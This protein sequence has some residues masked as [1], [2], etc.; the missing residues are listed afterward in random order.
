[1]AWGAGWRKGEGVARRGKQWAAAPWVWRCSSCGCGKNQWA[2]QCCGNCGKN[3]KDGWGGRRAQGRE[4]SAWDAGPPNHSRPHKQAAAPTA[5]PSQGAPEEKPTGEEA[6]ALAACLEVLRTLGTP[7]AKTALQALEA[8]LGPAA[9]TSKDPEKA[10]GPLLRKR[11]KK[12]AQL[13]RQQE[14]V[15]ACEKRLAEAKAREDEISEKLRAIQEE[16]SE[17]R[18]LLADEPPEQDQQTPPRPAR[19][20]NLGGDRASGSNNKHSD[21]WP[22]L[23]QQRETW[24]QQRQKKRRQRGP[25]AGGEESEEA[26]EGRGDSSDGG[27]EAE[28]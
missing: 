11:D 5:Q 20:P 4:G 3:W 7:V 25:A 1:M 13:D 27:M 23:Q 28:F 16:L 22:T 17:V 12:Q 19:A 24:Q 14:W 2:Q 21:V 10:I 6:T 8:S 15:A 18:R 26:A 9:A